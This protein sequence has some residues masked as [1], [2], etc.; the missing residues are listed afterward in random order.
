MA[1][2]S[3]IKMDKPQPLEV[4]EI[5]DCIEE[6]QHSKGHPQCQAHGS[7][8]RAQILMLRMGE[9]QLYRSQLASFAAAEAKVAADDAKAAAEAAH[10]VVTRAENA[11]NT[12][13]RIDPSRM[14][15]IAIAYGGWAAAVFALVA[16]VWTTVWKIKGWL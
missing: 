13:T 14:L 8:V 7:S 2:M 1:P 3:D 5:T 9:I 11:V 12:R 10:A 15:G 4:R 16:A 6:L